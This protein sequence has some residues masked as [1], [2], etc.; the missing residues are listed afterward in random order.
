TEYRYNLDRQ[1]TELRRPDGVVVGFG[2]EATTGRPST[3]TFD[4][5]T[6]GMSYSATTGQL[7]S[8]TAPG[9]ISQ[10]FTYDGILPKTVTWSGPVAGSVGVGCNAD[11][12]VT[13]QTV[14]GANSLSF[15]YD[16]DGLLTGAGALGLKRHAHHGLVERDSVGSAGTYVLGV[17]A[18]DP[19]GGLLSYTASHTGSGSPL[20]Q[21]SYLRDSLGRITELTETIQGTTATLAYSYDSAGR[22]FDVRRDGT[23]TATYEYDHN[24]NRERLTTVGG[25][26][27][28]NYDAQDRLTAYGT[29]TYTYTAN[30]ELRTSAVPG[31]GTMTSTYDAFGN[32]TAVALPDGTKIGYLIDGANRRIGKTVNGTRVQGF[33]YQ[34]QLQPVAELN[35]SNQVVSRFVYG[36]RPNVPEYLIKGG[37]TYRLVLDHLGSVRLVV[38]TADGTVS[39]RIDYDEFGRV[40][41]N[42]NPGFQPF[43]YAGGL[44]DEHTGL[45]RFGA[46]DY[47]PTTGRWTAKDPIGFASGDAN[48]YAYVSNQPITLSDPTGHFLV[49]T[50]AGAAIGAATGA[51]FGALGAIATGGSV[52]TVIGAALYGAAVG[53]VS[54]ALQGSGLGVAIATGAVVGG[55]AG[56]AVESFSQ[57]LSSPD[58]YAY[59]GVQIGRAAA[60]GAAGGVAGVLTPGGAGA[61]FGSFVGGILD[62]IRQAVYANSNRG[63]Q[64]PT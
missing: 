49:L 55:L 34:G 18:H 39:Q 51:Y 11:F 30:G 63:P 45:V 13:S 15:G 64:C 47:D 32:L 44:L 50:G 14:N 2:Y 43:G 22:L 31:V 36:G 8:L 28:G 26:V 23:L 61:F 4:R 37:Q 3:V 6:L 58:G 9:G 29:T 41:Q 5:G 62:L 33:L 52:G 46:R 53:T 56:A 10:S 1:L 27:T 12:R 19:K 48:T 17:W 24:G 20:F 54:G 35:G 59:D 42:T 7:T 40:T 57:Q 25:V 38:N 16:R 60:A 21:T